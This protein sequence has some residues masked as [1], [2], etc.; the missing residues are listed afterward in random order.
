MM[1][2]DDAQIVIPYAVWEY[3][4]KPNTAANS[5]RQVKV[6][7]LLTGIYAGYRYIYVG[8]EVFVTSQVASAS[9]TVANDND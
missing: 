6:I 7:L 9:A 2:I 5:K 8:N 4:T 3:V 1:I